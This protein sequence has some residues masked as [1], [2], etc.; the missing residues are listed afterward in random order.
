[1]GRSEIGSYILVFQAYQKGECG[2]EWA[3]KANL[4]YFKITNSSEEILYFNCPFSGGFL[5]KT[6]SKKFVE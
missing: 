1:M 2:M 3:N 5:L 4:H 6:V